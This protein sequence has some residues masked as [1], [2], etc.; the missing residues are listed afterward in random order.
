[1]MQKSMFLIEKRNTDPPINLTI[2]AYN[3]EPTK[4]PKDTKSGK[5]V[6]PN[7]ICDKANQNHV[8]NCTN[9]STKTELERSH[10]PHITHQVYH[11]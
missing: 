8:F 10:W 11:G 5:Y 7:K 1:M 6:L 3:K 2:I 4:S 9:C